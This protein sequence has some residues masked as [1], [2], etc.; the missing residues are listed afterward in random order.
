M[1]CVRS[2]QLSTIG[3][4]VCLSCTVSDVASSIGVTLKSR[5]GH[6]RSVEVA[7]LIDRER[8]PIR[9]PL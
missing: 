4:N 7:P 1:A 5:S 2:L 6:L 3:L 9:R 8:V